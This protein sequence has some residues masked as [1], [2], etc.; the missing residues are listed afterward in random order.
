MACVHIGGVW[1]QAPEECRNEREREKEKERAKD[2]TIWL[3][4]W[5]YLL[6]TFRS[7]LRCARGEREIA[8]TAERKLQQRQQ[9]DHFSVARLK[10]LLLLLLPLK[11]LNYNTYSN[12]WTHAAHSRRRQALSAP[13][14]ARHHHQQ[15]QQTQA[16]QT[17]CA[18][19]DIRTREQL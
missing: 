9:E 3:A 11:G 1:A 15:Q 13:N 10:K 8:E 14:S 7:Q 18:A 5:L 19:T 4:N 16:L 6:L 2:R 17:L 12:T